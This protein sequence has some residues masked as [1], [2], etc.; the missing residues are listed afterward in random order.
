MYTDYGDNIDSTYSDAS[1]VGVGGIIMNTQ[2]VSIVVMIVIENI[3]WTSMYI[4]T[5]RMGLKGSSAHR[6]SVALNLKMSFPL[7]ITTKVCENKQ[8]DKQNTREKK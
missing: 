6:P 3:G 4:A 8:T 2:F 7:L 1:I 5:R